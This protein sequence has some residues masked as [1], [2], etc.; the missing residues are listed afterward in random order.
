MT[1]AK[2]KAI[3]END[4]VDGH[5]EGNSKFM[6][7]FWMAVDA[8]EYDD[9][10]YHEEH[11]EVIVAKELWEDAEKALRAIEDIKTEILEETKCHYGDKC[12]GANCPS[13]TDCMIM[14]EHAIWIINK[15]IGERSEE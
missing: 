11:G 13:N 6:D 7:A 3:L 9:A 4:I 12:L 15:H 2:A 14:G 5:V 8:L 1:R 10:K